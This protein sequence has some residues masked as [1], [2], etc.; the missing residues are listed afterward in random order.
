MDFT[1]ISVKKYCTMFRY[2]FPNFK[3]LFTLPKRNI[4]KQYYHF[5]ERY[6]LTYSTSKYDF[7]LFWFH[8]P[9]P[10][11]STVKQMGK[12]RLG[13]DNDCHLPSCSHLSAK[14]LGPPLCLWSPQGLGRLQ[15]LAK[16]LCLPGSHS[17]LKLVLISIL[18]IQTSWFL[19]FTE[20]GGNGK[21]CKGENIGNERH[22]WCMVARSNVKGQQEQVDN[23]RFQLPISEEVIGKTAT[24]DEKS[25]EIEKFCVLRI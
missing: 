8:L 4:R 18:L 3:A 7:Y 14:L 12:A 19:I 25:N 16:V 15:L 21:A 5:A 9:L 11:N 24:N 17:V 2:H 22:S 1:C 10:K 6:G 23:L 13:R 20:W